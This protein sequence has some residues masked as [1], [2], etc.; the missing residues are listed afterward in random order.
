MSH[1]KAKKERQ[2]EVLDGGKS[3]SDV[4]ARPPRVLA[5]MKIQVL[6]NGQVQVVNIPCMFDDAMNL[7]ANATRAVAALFVQN[8]MH[9]KVRSERGSGLLVPAGTGGIILPG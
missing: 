9:G 8:A 4:E 7:L 6:D 1:K 3:A 5:E 2:M